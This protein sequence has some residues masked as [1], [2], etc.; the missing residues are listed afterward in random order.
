MW[1][2]QTEQTSEL[3]DEKIVKCKDEKMDKKKDETSGQAKN[4]K[5]VM[6]RVLHGNLAK[7]ERHKKHKNEQV[8]RKQSKKSKPQNPTPHPQESRQITA[9]KVP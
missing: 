3:R 8:M 4:L 1:K 7:P 5:R 9:S 6:R 2:F